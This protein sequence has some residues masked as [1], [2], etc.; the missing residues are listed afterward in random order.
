M[1]DMRFAKEKYQAL[2]DA[3]GL[4][5]GGWGRNSRSCSRCNG[6][7]RIAA[8]KLNIVITACA[9]DTVAV[10]QALDMAGLT[11]T[12]TAF[13][14]K[15]EAEIARGAWEGGEFTISR[16]HADEVGHTQMLNRPLTYNQI[17]GLL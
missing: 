12:Y 8:G 7:T 1:T 13:S 10:Q 2:K 6:G 3:L 9:N 17:M 16:A 15:S 11:A 4:N 14:T 5:G